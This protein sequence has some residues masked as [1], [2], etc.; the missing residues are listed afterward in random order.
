MNLTFT[1]KAENFIRR[2]I[3]FGGGGAG[4]GF[5]LIVT[6]GG[7]S[8]FNTDFTVE[9][10]PFPGDAVIDSGGVRMFLPME[11]RLLLDGFIVDF[12]DTPSETGLKFYN[13]NAPAACGCST[14]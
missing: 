11:T 4:A 10:E 3:R 7:C 6:P 2:M 9:T 1:V 5:R 13:P 12:T 8:G 14:S